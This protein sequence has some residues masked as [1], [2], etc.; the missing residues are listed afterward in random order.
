MSQILPLIQELR[1][2][3]NPDLNIGGLL[4]TMFCEEL[5]LSR[6]VAHEVCDYFQDTVFETLIPRDVVL[7]EASS[8]GLPAYKYAPLS[9]GAWSYIE[10]AREV[11]EHDWS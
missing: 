2:S 8:H 1:S 3:I 7:A 10:L 6:E 5:D 4:L 11:L 9:R